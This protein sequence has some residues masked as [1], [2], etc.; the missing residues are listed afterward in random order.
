M[1]GPAIAFGFAI[2]LIGAA[3]IFDGVFPPHRERPSRWPQRAGC[4]IFEGC[5]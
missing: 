3:L 5:P 1:K 4:I 2:A